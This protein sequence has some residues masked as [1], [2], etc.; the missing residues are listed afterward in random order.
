MNIDV[1]IKRI[2]NAYYIETSRW[3]RDFF[4]PRINDGIV[5]FTEGRIEYDF[6]SKKLIAQKGDVLLL[7][8][9]IPYS[10]VK[11]T[12]KVAFYVLDFECGAENEFNEVL[13]ASVVT[14]SE[15]DIFGLKFSEAVAAWKK[16]LLGFDFEI[17]SFAYYARSNIISSMNRTNKDD[18]STEA[19]LEFIYRNISDPKLDLLGICKKF[20]ISDSQLR[21]NVYKYTGMN[22]N[23]YIL[24]IR[25][26]MAQIELV[27][28]QK[29]IKCISEICGF[30]S[31]YYFSKC[32]SKRFGMS[33]KEFRA[34][35]S[36]A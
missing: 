22:P 31:P 35:C 21:R 4:A 28:T 34:K 5:L 32:F 1:N 25:L 3:Q 12:D 6:G 8:G 29:S 10:G 23:R 30:S 18:G 9:N 19:I 27:N 33:P 2:V 26:D 24:K 17:K 13:G 36:N 7:P 15:P 14:I 20:F 11:K 16:Q